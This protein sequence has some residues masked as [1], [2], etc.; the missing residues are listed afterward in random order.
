M[1]K[2]SFY[3]TSDYGNLPDDIG[4][5]AGQIPSAVQTLY[6]ILMLLKQGQASGINV[7]PEQKAFIADAG[8]RLATGTRDGQIQQSFV[9]SFFVDSGVNGLPRLD[10][11][12]AV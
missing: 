8:R 3:K 2:E 10:Q 1:Q 5:S 12:D 9:I 6:G 11:V 4:I 7:D